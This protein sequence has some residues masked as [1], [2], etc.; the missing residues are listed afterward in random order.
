LFVDLHLM[1]RLERAKLSC[2]HIE[3]VGSQ[4]KKGS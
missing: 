3:E 4:E 1:L 2:N